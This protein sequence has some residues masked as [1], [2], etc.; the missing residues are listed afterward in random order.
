MKTPNFNAFFGIVLATTSLLGA[1]THFVVTDKPP[2]DD[3]FFFESPQPSARAETMQQ[4]ENT[5][6]VSTEAKQQANPLVEANAMPDESLG[7]PTP[8]PKVTKA[9][10][11]SSEC[12]S[13]NTQ[14][15]FNKAGRKVEEIKVRATGYGAPPKAFYSDQQRR[16]MSM[17]AAKID[18]YRSLA[19]RVKGIQ[20]WG[21]TTIGDMVVEKDRFRV[22][23]DTFLVGAKVIMQTPHEDGTYEATVEMNVGQRV[24]QTMM[25]NNIIQA[26]VNDPCADDTMKTNHA[27]PHDPS[28]VPTRATQMVQSDFYFDR[29]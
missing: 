12:T 16:L 25:Y 2:A 13:T 29:D 15:Y 3:D 19:E 21:G 24:V 22:F 1:C 7:E 18:A 5:T 8:M 10:P 9:A 11:A 20:I 27:R 14:P 17:R 26:P 4:R 23:L 28:M 6:K